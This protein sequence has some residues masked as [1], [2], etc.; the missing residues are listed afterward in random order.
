MT[1]YVEIA[2]DEV[3]SYASTSSASDSNTISGSV[4]MSMDMLCEGEEEL[5]GDCRN[6]FNGFE[7]GHLDTLVTFTGPLECENCIDLDD[8]GLCENVDGMDPVRTIDAT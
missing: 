1:D 8:D 6:T 3:D 2:W 5:A 4:S 7:A